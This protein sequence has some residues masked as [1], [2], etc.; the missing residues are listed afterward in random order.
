M[1]AWG[2]CCVIFVVADLI[3][4]VVRDREALCID[5]NA[6]GCLSNVMLLVTVNLLSSKNLTANAKQTV[7]IVSMI[8]LGSESENIGRTI[9]YLYLSFNIEARCR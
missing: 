9:H 2:S 7:A 4:D 1:F 3:A 5:V 8:V 6:S